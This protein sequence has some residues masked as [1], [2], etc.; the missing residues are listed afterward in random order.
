MASSLDA[1]DRTTRTESK[2]VEG[3]HS[4]R[5]YIRRERRTTSSTSAAAP[6]S[7]RGRLP[8]SRI[9]RAAHLRRAVRPRTRGHRARA[10]RAC[11]ARRAAAPSAAQRAKPARH[12]RHRRSLPGELVHESSHR[13]RVTREL[14]RRP[15]LIDVLGGDERRIAVDHPMPARHH[16]PSARVGR[17][18]SST[19]R[20]LASR[21]SRSAL[22]CPKH[23]GFTSTSR[24][25]RRRAAYR[26]LERDRAS[27]RLRHDVR[28][29]QRVAAR[30]TRAPRRR[31]TRACTGPDRSACRTGHGPEDRP[32]R[33]VG[34]PR[35]AAR[36]SPATCRSRRPIRAR[37]ARR[38]RRHRPIP[39]RGA[40]RR[41]KRHPVD[42]NVRPSRR[43]RSPL[44]GVVPCERAAAGALGR[45]CRPG[46]RRSRSGGRRGARSARAGR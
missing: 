42:A 8:R 17:A 2:R 22:T 11:R 25:H 36:T 28:R 44:A 13:A 31:A 45:P 41:R 6:R 27:H 26:Q 34:Q 18:P 20:G 15:V 39:R 19:A 37:A 23:A 38:A 40:R 9:P 43:E 46:V 5:A 21:A 29:V 3:L 7:P 1:P 16:P 33:R 35:R 32:Q 24:P 10:G 12:H 30:S 4:L 14:R